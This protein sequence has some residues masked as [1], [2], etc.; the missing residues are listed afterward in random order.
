MEEWLNVTI[1]RITALKPD[2]VLEVGCGTGLL[3]ERLAPY[4][5]FYHATDFSRVAIADLK[6]W[7]RR[8]GWLGHVR[9]SHTDALDFDGTEP[10]SIDVVV[11]NSVIQYFP[12]FSYF[13]TLIQRASDLLS[14]GG[15]LFIGDVR[16]LCLLPT[17]HTSV[18]FA[19][20]PQQCTIE[21]LKYRIGQKLTNEKEFLI[22]PQFFHLVPQLIPRI[23]SADVMVKQGR[24]D[25]ELT[26]YRYDVV[27]HCDKHL[28]RNVEYTVEWRGRQTLDCD[29]LPF[30]RE[31]RFRCFCI[32]NIPNRK[33]SRDLT[34]TESLKNNLELMYVDELRRY[35]DR[36]AIVGEDPETFSA[37]GDKYSF[38]TKIILSRNSCHAHFDVTFS[39]RTRSNELWVR[40]PIRT[41]SVDQ[42][43][44]IY[45][46]D[47]LRP[48]V[49]QRLIP[50]L[51]GALESSLPDYMV[52]SAFV[53]LP[54]LPLTPNG[55]V[56]RA[57]LPAPESLEHR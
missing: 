10:G 41:R 26:R 18:Q 14:S 12:N 34:I 45:F 1:E 32:K 54:A 4:C 50:A 16:N 39:D 57:A 13:I 56:D 17:F 28:V 30:L 53:T 35:I 49:R 23:S 8:R 38:D 48:M 43:W 15:T 37:L 42:K 40:S 29:L 44:G 2:R 51:K 3:L 21:Q 5:Q 24:F 7:T 46:S 6:D 20:S 11:I 31:R 36:C 55:K 33:L 25:N 47:P 27:L 52:P 19:R 9:L 22:D